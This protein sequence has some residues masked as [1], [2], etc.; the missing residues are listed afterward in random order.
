MRLLSWI[1]ELDRADQVHDSLLAAA[2]AGS[3]VAF[4]IAAVCAAST[5]LRRGN[6]AAA[7]AEARTATETAARHGL[8]FYEPFARALLGEAL[9]ERGDLGQAAAAVNGMNLGQIRGSGPGA[10]LLYVRGRLRGAVGDRDGATAD[11]RECGETYEAMGYCNPNILPWRSALAQV[12][13]RAGEA[14]ALATEELARARHAGQPRG[15]GIALRACALLSPRHEQ[16]PLLQEAAEALTRSPSALELARV[17]T[18]H[19]TALARSGQRAGAREPLQDAM[20]LAARC[21]AQPL[22]QRARDELR[23][24]GA[25]PRRERRTGIDSLTPGELGV[26]RL[27]GDGLTTRQIAQAL[28]VSA[29][30]VSTHLGHIYGKLA[31]NNRED[32]TRIMRENNRAPR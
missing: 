23:A 22:A 15:I 32:L 2:R 20:D 27:A 17:L 24:V 7:E 30:T 10:L 6:L 28:F 14:Q 16:L 25:R 19:G 8:K 11:L 3:I 29:K 31:I 5:A 12:T 21:G 26:A 9:L 13:P 1:D 18:D 4:A